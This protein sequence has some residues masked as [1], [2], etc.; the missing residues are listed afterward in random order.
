MFI[1]LVRLPT[2]YET[3]RMQHTY[4]E[5]HCSKYVNTLQF[6]LRVCCCAKLMYIF[7]YFVFFYLETLCILTGLS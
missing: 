5:L 3:D 2:S 1:V 7:C 4:T 6:F